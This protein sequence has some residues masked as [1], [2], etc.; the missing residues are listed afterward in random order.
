MTATAPKK[1]RL[2]KHVGS[3][4]RTQEETDAPPSTKSGQVKRV[5]ASRWTKDL[6]VGGW[7]PISNFFLSHANELRPE[8]TGGETLFIIHLISFKWDEKKPYPAFKTI[9]KRMGIG[10]T[11]ARKLARQ[12]EKKGLLFR[13]MR[14][15]QPNKFDLQPLFRKLEELRNKKLLEEKAKAA[16]YKPRRI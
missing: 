16:R 12:L 11:Q 8:I 1:V 10:H 15:S 2:R 7:T 5:A 14:V 3:E 9:A 4:R 13:V 6:V